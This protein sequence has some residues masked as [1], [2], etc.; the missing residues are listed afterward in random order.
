M[1]SEESQRSTDRKKFNAQTK[2][3]YLCFVSWQIL[4]QKL[5]IMQKIKLKLPPIQKI[6][7]GCQGLICFKGPSP[8][9]MHCMYTIVYT[10]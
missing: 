9:T 6:K 2:L 4:R 1:L 5:L 8:L 7:L 3:D 10:V